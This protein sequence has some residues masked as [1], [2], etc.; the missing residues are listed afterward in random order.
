LS[1]TGSKLRS[2]APSRSSYAAAEAVT[3]GAIVTYDVMGSVDSKMPR[4]GPIVATMGFYAA[5]AAVGSISRT[6]EPAVVATGW[7]LALS[8]LVTG[9]RGAG[10]LHVFQKLASIV[11]NVGSSS[12]VG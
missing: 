9:K 1:S 6:F 8:V 3:L 4:P 11:G 10:L 2:W 12:A 5:L 7:V